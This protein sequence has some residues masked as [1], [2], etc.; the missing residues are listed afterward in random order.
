MVDEPIE[1][2]SITPYDQ[3]VRPRAGR[4]VGRAVAAGLGWPA[5]AVL[6]V[7]ASFF[8]VFSVTTTITETEAGAAGLIGYAFD[9]WGRISTMHTGSEP[10]DVGGASGPRYGVL[11]CIAA[12]VVLLG[13]LHSL[14]A[15]RSDQRPVG[16]VV[17]G[18]GCAFLAGVV[19]CEVVATLPNRN[20]FPQDDAVF[21][22]GPSP[23]LAGCACVLG[24]LTWAAQWH[25]Q[26]GIA[27]A[28]DDSDTSMPATTA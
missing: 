8:R 4:P 15:V 2:S 13:W 3:S 25:V 23:W 11:Y 12:G 28:D 21:T 16:R 22:F 26:R 27:T 20:G 19:A 10:F 5:V 9:G 17:S 18:A 1:I 7:M 24:S 14:L 6:A